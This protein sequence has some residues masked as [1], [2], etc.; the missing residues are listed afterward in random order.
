M[1]VAEQTLPAD[2]RTRRAQR[3][4]AAV[5]RAC[6]ELMARG[7]FGPPMHACTDRAGL[8]PR[9]G[10]EHFKTVENLW[11]EALADPQMPPLIWRALL[12]G[13]RGRNWRADVVFAAVFG[14]PMT[15][16]ERH[17]PHP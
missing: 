11:R 9:T 4:R 7:Q 3:S 8:C 16:E 6:R 13:N 10:F 14:R 12:A 2:G 1:T 5:L 15:A 17:G